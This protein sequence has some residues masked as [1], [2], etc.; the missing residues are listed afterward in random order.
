M[1][2]YSEIERNEVLIH[3]I[4]WMN[5]KG[6]MLTEKNQSQKFTCHVI[7]LI[8]LLNDKTIELENGC[9]QRSRWHYKR[10]TWERF[11]TIMEQF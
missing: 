2:Y 5:L 9:G 1:D 11:F 10:L 3:V 8:I 4:I 7:P 6:F